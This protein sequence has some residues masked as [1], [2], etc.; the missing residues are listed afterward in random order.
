[1]LSLRVKIILVYMIL[2]TATLSVLG[3]ALYHRLQLRL[4]RDIDDVLLSRAEGI[5]DSIDTY[6]E[7]E[8]AEA[9]KAGIRLDDVRELDRMPFQKM[10]QDWVAEKSR[11]LLLLNIIVHIFDRSGGLIASSKVMPGNVILSPEIFE[12]IAQNMTRFDNIS[13]DLGS[14]KPAHVRALTIPVTVNGKLTYIVQVTTPLS[15]L[16]SALLRLRFV[17]F[18]LLPLAIVFS[19][20]VSV[21]L[22][23]MTLNPVNRII[24]TIHRITAESLELRISPPKTND[25]IRRLA[26][27][28][29]EMLERLERTFVSQQQFIEDLSHELK[30]PLAILRGELEVTLKK[31]RSAKEY[32]AILASSLEEINRIIRV[33]D[34]LL[35]LVKF[36][37]RLVDLEKS[38]CD[39]GGLAREAVDDI[40]PLASARGVK[41]AIESTGPQ[42]VLGERDKLKRVLL[43]LLDNAIKYSPA[44]GEV[45][46]AVARAGAEVRISVRDAGPGIPGS[47]RSRIFDRFYRVD[48]SRSTS[49]FGL[50]LSIAKSLIDA[51]GGRID[52]ESP[53][54]SGST[55]TVVLPAEH[56]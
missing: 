25:E 1:M 30:T 17:L 34:D 12:S 10:A 56:D 15:S 16:T 13:M 55:F 36:D 7:T 53:P 29:N 46:V 22:A 43:S 21:V 49:G 37:S 45:R 19:G 35:M 33:T 51:H 42:F 41:L 31:I 47:E 6:W 8:K 5:V 26:E 39:V 38:P 27:T 18:L 48:K 24:D 54:G 50:G 28:F 4:T 23:R 11:D 3:A 20:A 52:V 14:A 40:R 2:M 9:A 44:G 32:E